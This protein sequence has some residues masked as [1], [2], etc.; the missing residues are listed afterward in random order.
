MCIMVGLSQFCGWFRVSFILVE[1]FQVKM[2]KLVHFWVLHDKP[3]LRRR[4]ANLGGP[5]TS[6]EKFLL[7]LGQATV[8][9]LFFFG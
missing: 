8:P 5:E 6:S 2:A 1:R 9:V 3:T 7:R 4:S